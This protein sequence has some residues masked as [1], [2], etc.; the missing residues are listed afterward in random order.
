MLQQYGLGI[1]SSTDTADP[2]GDGVDNYH[3]WLAGTDPTNPLSTPARL[4]ITPAGTNVILTWRKLH[5]GRPRVR[6]ALLSRFQNARDIAHALQIN[7]G[8]VS[9][10]SKRLGG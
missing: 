9:D 7:V 2:D 6:I 4:T 10:T 8:T 1:N 5:Q 3:E